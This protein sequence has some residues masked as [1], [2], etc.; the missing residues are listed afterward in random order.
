MYCMDI[1][2]KFIDTATILVPPI[3]LGAASGY[4]YAK[5]S[6]LSANQVARGWA[7]WF[8]TSSSL[9]TLVNILVKPG[10][11]RCYIKDIVW[12]IVNIAGCIKLQERGLIGNKM[13]MMSIAANIFHIAITILFYNT[14]LFE[15]PLTKNENKEMF[16]KQIKN[17]L[18]E[19]T[20]FL[21]K[22]S[23]GIADPE[24]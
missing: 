24:G 9:T 12:T 2:N 19:F 23:L 4:C 18:S 15:S 3:V 10:S 8:A 7:V 20:M 16:I 22:F 11:T 14:S 17:E 1:N 21:F 13:I 5:F 6:H